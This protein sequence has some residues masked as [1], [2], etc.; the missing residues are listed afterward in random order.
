MPELASI[1]ASLPTTLAQ[2]AAFPRPP[3][4]PFIDPLELHQWWWLL[5][6]PMSFGVAV[7]YKAVRVKT[8]DKYWQQVLIMTIQIV[9]GM[10]ALAAASYWLVM[11]FAQFI[12]ERAG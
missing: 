7:V 8:M 11:H 12:A 3:Y 1:F 6:I 4:R 10:L 5:L 9:L 2:A